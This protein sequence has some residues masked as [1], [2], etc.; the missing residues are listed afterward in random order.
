MIDLQ[1]AARQKLIDCARRMTALGLNSGTAGNLSVRAQGGFLITPTGMDYAALQ[2]EDIVFMDLDG[3][4]SGPR[5]PSSE[6]RFHRDLYLARP[7]ASAVLHAHSPFATSIA[8]LRRDLPPFHYMIARFGGDTLRCA[9]YATFGSQ[10]LSDAALAAIAGRCACLLAN[11][12]MLV[13]GG[14]LDQALAL[15]GELEALCEQY[16]RACAI[17]T[18]VLLDAAEMATVLDKFASYGQQR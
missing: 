17:G 2:P 13:F 4:P 6:W 16:W 5:Q 14:D 7:E 18:P 15:G 3:T 1:T 12:G 9:A 10:A 11:H 8:C